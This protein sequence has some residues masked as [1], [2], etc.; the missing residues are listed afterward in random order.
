MLKTKLFCRWAKKNQLSDDALSKAVSEIEEGLVEAD[1]G[2][3]IYKK[4][5]A[6]KGKGKSGSV[7]TVLAYKAKNR[8][9]F[10]YAFEKKQRDNISEKEIKALKIL[11]AYLLNLT[12]R[13]I[14][15]KIIDGSLSIIE[16]KVDK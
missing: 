2:S 5:I 3:N 4:R 1:L 11:G 7:R 8:V 16:N 12:S 14:D 13:Q 15:N 9:F 6:T 10:L